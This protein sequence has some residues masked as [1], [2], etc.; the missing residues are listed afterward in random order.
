MW[1]IVCQMLFCS[2][3]FEKSE[4]VVTVT[5][6]NTELP[7]NAFVVSGF[8][9]SGQIL[10]DGQ[11][12]QN[13]EFLLFNRKNVSCNRIFFIEKFNEILCTEKIRELGSSEPLF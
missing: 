10:S 7:S 13:V 1:K 6:G 12:L 9:V 4:Y 5:A 11:A 2:W 8:D 3:Y